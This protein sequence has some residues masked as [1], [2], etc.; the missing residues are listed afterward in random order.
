MKT[1]LRL[2]L[3]AAGAWTLSSCALMSDEDRDFYGK[4]WINPRELDNAPRMPKH[5]ESTGGLGGP[6]GQTP[7]SAAAQVQ[8]PILDE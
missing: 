6:A 5:P 7:T 1:T 8:D 4:G 2:L 3:L